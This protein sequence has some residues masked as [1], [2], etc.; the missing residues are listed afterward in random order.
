MWIDLGTLKLVGENFGYGWDYTDVV[1]C[2]ET[3]LRDG[4]GSF[5]R[6]SRMV[7]NG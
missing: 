1:V 3:W 6:N 7:D 4:V 2:G 5:V